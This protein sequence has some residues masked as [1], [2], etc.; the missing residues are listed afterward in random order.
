MWLGGCLL[1]RQPIRLRVA[2]SKGNP[3]TLMDQ[4]WLAVALKAAARL[5]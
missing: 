3:T 2:Y 4:D 5:T 1:E